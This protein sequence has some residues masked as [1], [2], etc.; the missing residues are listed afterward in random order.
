MTVA[1]I[2][3]I[4]LILLL[5]GLVVSF[6]VYKIKKSDSKEATDELSREREK[7]SI[8]K[9]KAFIKKQFD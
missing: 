3:N 8:E 2:F 4:L 7:Y 5:I 9:M 1:F 6:F